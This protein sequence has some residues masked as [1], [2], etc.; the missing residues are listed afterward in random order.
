MY[1]ISTFY[2][3]VRISDTLSIQNL[4]K[5]FCTKKAIKGTIL[6]AKE[7]INATIVGKEVAIK[8][9]HIFIS[10]LP[11]FTDLFSQESSYEFMPFQKLKVKIKPEIVTFKVQ[12]LDM[13]N[14]GQYIKPE[15]WDAFISRSDV[16][17]IDIRNYYEVAMGSFKNAISPNTNN[18]TDLVEWIE[19]NLDEKDLETSIA[20]FCTG[21]VRCEKS[22]VYM[23]KL[24]YKNVYHLQGG[25]I[26]YL[27]NNKSDIW[28]GSCFIFDDRVTFDERLITN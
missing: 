19:K 16:K 12:D 4:L 1:I 27:K 9:F 6:I 2:K 3:F 25:I 8:E 5:D 7:G 26:N 17:V 20:M 24:G 11:H 14:T 15:D 23:K 22:S 28:E 18:F 13:S 21:G 10:S